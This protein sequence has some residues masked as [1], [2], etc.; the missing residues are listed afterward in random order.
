MRKISEFTT[1]HGA[2][3]KVWGD[4]FELRRKF[5][6]EMKLKVFN[7]EG[8]YFFIFSVKNLTYS[9]REVHVYGHDRETLTV[10]VYAEEVKDLDKY[11]FNLGNINI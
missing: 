11:E 10:E 6:G 5:D 3:H 8:Q 9:C 1:T 7:E 4:S 2:L